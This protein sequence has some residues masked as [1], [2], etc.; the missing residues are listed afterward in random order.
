MIDAV[1]DR[2]PGLLAHELRNPLASAMTGAMLARDMVDEGDPRATVL[3]GV[4]RDLD[5]MTGL[6]DG[7]LGIARGAPA[8]DA[9]VDLEG[10]LR[11]VAGRH[12]A[13]LVTCPPA[14]AVRGSR[15]LL[16]RALDNLC[17]NARNAGAATIRI[18]AQHDGRRVAVHV[19]DDGRGVPAEHADRVFEP[20]WSRGG[21]TGL[22]LFAVAATLAACDGAVRCVPLDRGTRFTMTLSRATAVAT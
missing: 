13:E 7:W 14:L 17:E 19:E 6:L 20:G 5:R 9:A 2:L 16:E 18:A 12:R 11:A 1:A 21:G 8:V 10:L 4:L 15:P 22:G 3:D